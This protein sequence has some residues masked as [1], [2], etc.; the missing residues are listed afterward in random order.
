MPDWYQ[1]VRQRLSGLALNSA[2]K[3]DV[4]AE[5]AGHLEE[6]CE[7]L[8]ATGLPEQEAVRR[9]LAQIPD[10]QDLQ[11]RISYAKKEGS[12]MQKRLHQLWIPGFL[13][14]TFSATFLMTLQKY[15]SRP[16]IISWS[17]P[18]TLLFYTAWLMSLPLFGA[19]GAYLSSRAGGSRRAV[20]M[21][22]VFPVLALA[23]TFFFTLPVSLIIDRFTDHH[24]SPGIVATSFLM[25]LVG[26]VLVPG[27]AL[28]I[29]G[30]P[31]QIF[32][33]RRPGPRETAI[34]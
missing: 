21:A 20:L 23:G 29:G 26:W 25:Y 17:G 22:S 27:A 16:R 30:L 1:L 28:L 3:E 15:G 33:S 5:L 34:D 9:T 18:G 4:H 13:T 6:S 8:R 24:V 11:Q 19:L 14:L 10:W 32:L 12:V 2:D 31:T 7:G